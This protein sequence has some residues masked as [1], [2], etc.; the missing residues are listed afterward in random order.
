M[1]KT[2]SSQWIIRQITINSSSRPTAGW[3]TANKDCR[4]IL[5]L[6][7][8]HQQYEIPITSGNCTS[9]TIFPL[10]SSASGLVHALIFRSLFPNWFDLFVDK[11]YAVRTVM[12]DYQIDDTQL[13]LKSRFSSHLKWH[14]SRNFSGITPAHKKDAGYN[15][16]APDTPWYTEQLQSSQAS[17]RNKTRS[18]ICRRHLSRGILQGLFTV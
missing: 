1:H 10:S 15:P 5:K 11:D 3:W 16:D 17:T 2:I 6:Y 18:Y 13:R 8:C 4:Q 9:V 7:H 12:T 14:N